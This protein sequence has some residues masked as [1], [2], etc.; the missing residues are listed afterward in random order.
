MKRENILT[1]LVAFLIVMNG[2][3]LFYF[4]RKGPLPEPPPDRIIV[5]VLQFDDRQRDEF[6]KLK[7]DHH[8]KM[9]KLNDHF[10]K[11]LEDYFLTLQNNSSAKDSLETLISGLEKERLNITYSHFQDIKKLCRDD[12]LE[13]FNTF[14]PDLIRFVAAP[15]PKKDGPPRRN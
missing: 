3:I 14:L 11:T 8:G 1:W 5:E 15:L 10:R 2:A 6:R 9:M 4:M 7:D 13:K 12:Q